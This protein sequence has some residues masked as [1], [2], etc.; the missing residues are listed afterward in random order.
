MKVY[1]YF[2]L[3][4]SISSSEVPR[5]SQITKVIAD[6]KKEIISFVTENISVVGVGC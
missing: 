1:K 5:I 4:Y 6:C 2:L 3:C